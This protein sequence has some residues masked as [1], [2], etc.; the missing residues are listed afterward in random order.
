MKNIK[1]GEKNIKKPP[2]FILFLMIFIILVLYLIYSIGLNFKPFAI[3]E[4]EGYAVS[5]KELVE[6]LLKSDLNAKQYIDAVKIEEDSTIYKK[7]ASYFVGENKK[8]KINLDYPIYINKNIALLN[9]SDEGTLITTDLETVDAYKNS[10]LTN[11][12][13]YNVDSFERADY[14]DY[15]FLKN[16]DNVFINS[17]EMTIKTNTNTYVIP[18]NSMLSF[19]EEYIAY[20]HLE[21]GMFKYKSIIDIDSSSKV[22]INGIEYVRTNNEMVSNSTTKEYT[23][24]QFLTNLKLVREPVIKRTEEPKEE[25]NTPIEDNNDN[26][27]EEPSQEPQEP[28]KPEEIKWTKPQVTATDFIA[29]V[30]TADTNLSIYDPSGVIKTA[31]TFEIYKNGKIYMRNQAVSS[32]TIKIGVLEPDTEYEIRGIYRYSDK[33]DKTIENE[34]IKQKIKTKDISGLSPI[35]LSFENGK[36]YYNKIEIKNIKVASDMKENLE[37]L[38]GIKRAEITINGKTETI[39]SNGLR[40][41]VNGQAITFESKEGLKSNTEVNYEIAFYDISNNKVKLENNIGKTNTCM[42]KPDVRIE[43][44]DSN[45]GIDVTLRT[46]VNNKDNV[47]I[48]NLHYIVYSASNTIVDQGI[49]NSNIITPKGL[50]LSKYYIVKVFGTYD[51]N[52]DNGIIENDNLGE[53]SFTTAKL[54]SFGD[55]YVDLGIKTDKIKNDSVTLDLLINTTTNKTNVELLKM[56]KQVSIVLS[57]RNEM[58]REETL[59]S[60]KLASLLSLEEINIPINRLNSNTNYSIEVRAILGIGNS[61]KEVT[62]IINGPKSF[63][64]LRNDAKLSIRNLFILKDMIDFDINIYDKDQAVKNGSVLLEILNTRDEVVLR[65]EIITTDKSY[66]ST[67]IQVTDLNES[68]RYYI[69]LTT[70]KYSVRQEESTFKSMSFEFN[71]DEKRISNA[72]RNNQNVGVIWT[73]NV[74]GKISLNSIKKVAKLDNVNLIDVSSNVNWYS[75]CFNTSNGY[76]KEYSEGDKILKLGLGNSTSQLYIYD[77]KS[78]LQEYNKEKI[79]ISFK[80]RLSKSS[81]KMYL[82]NGK[83]ISS[84]R[85]IEITPEN[86]TQLSDDWYEFNSEDIIPDLSTEQYIGISLQGEANSYVDIMELQARINNSILQNVE[87][88]EYKYDFISNFNLD[89][90]LYDETL[91]TMDYNPNVTNGVYYLKINNITDNKTEYK[92]YSDYAQ[93][94]SND[95]GENKNAIENLIVE[96]NLSR[97]KQYNIS[98][99]VRNPNVKERE[100]TLSSIYFNTYSQEIKNISSISDYLEIQPNGAYIFS[101]DINLDSGD[102]KFG[103]ENLYFNGEIDFNGKTIKRKIELKEDENYKYY[104]FYGLTENATFKNLYF[105]FSINL[106]NAEGKTNVAISEHN[107]GLVYEN[108]GNI[109]NVI[110]NLSSSTASPNHN[111]AIIGYT[112]TGTLENFVIYLNSNFYLNGTGALGFVNNVGGTIKNGYL[113]PYPNT[114]YSIKPAECGESSIKIG[115]LVANATDNGNISNVYSLVNIHNKDEETEQT[116]VTFTSGNVIGSLTNSTVSNIYSVGLGNVNKI[117]SRNGKA[118][119]TIGQLYNIDDNNSVI[120]SYFFVD[121]LVDN[122]EYNVK[123]NIAALSNREFQDNLLNI[124]GNGQFIVDNTIKDYFPQVRLSEVM[125]RQ[126]KIPMKKTIETD[127][128]ILMTKILEDGDTEKIIEFT[129][130]N[131]MEAK[132]DKLE[133]E[134]LELDEYRIHSNEYCGSG[135]LF[136]KC[137][138]QDD[139]GYCLD[140][141]GNR[142]KVEEDGYTQEYLSGQTTKLIAKIRIPL[143]KTIDLKGFDSRKYASKYYLKSIKALGYGEKQYIDENGYILIKNEMNLTYY[144]H[145]QN[146]DDWKRINEYPTENYRIISD[147]DF[148]NYSYTDYCIKSSFTGIID[149]KNLQGKVARLSNLGK[150]ENEIKTQL[151]YKLSDATISN[152]MIDGFYQIID[153]KNVN[154]N[155]FL[156]GLIGV[157][158]QGTIIENVHLSNVKLMT[159]TTKNNIDDFYIGG[160]IANAELTTIKNCSISY[161]DSTPAVPN[162]SDLDGNKLSTA[163]IGGLVGLSRETKIYN[164]F[165]TNIYINANLKTSDGI[166][167]LVGRYTGEIINCYTTGQIK[168]NAQEIGGIFGRTL[169]EGGTTKDSN[170]CNN[171]YSVV[172]IKT[173]SSGLGGI[174]GFVDTTII[175]QLE[176]NI[177]IGNLYTSMAGTNTNSNRIYGNIS[178]TSTVNYAYKEQLING[179]KIS[180]QDKNY[181]RGAKYVVDRENLLLNF[182]GMF[183]NSVYNIIDLKNAYL[184]R[185]KYQ[186]SQDLLPNQTLNKVPENPT[187]E[188]VSATAE[189]DK[190]KIVIKDENIKPVSTSYINVEIVDFEDLQVEKRE[191]NESTRMHTLYLTGKPIY[192]LD[193]YEI[194]KLM[195]RANN[196]EDYEAEI[197]VKIDFLN[198]KKISSTEEWAK[199]FCPEYSGYNYHKVDGDGK[200]EFITGQNYKIT[201]DIDLTELQTLNGETLTTPTKLEIGRLVGEDNSKE[202]KCPIISNF[203]LSTRGTYSAIF[204]SITKELKNIYFKDID[205]DNAYGDYTGIV[206]KCTAQTIENLKFTN[207]KLKSTSSFTAVISYSTCTNIKNIKLENIE[208]TGRAYVAGFMGY[209]YPGTINNIEANNITIDAKKNY[210]GG[211]F[212]YIPNYVSSYGNNITNLKITNSS[213]KSKE[214]SIGGVAGYAT[215]KSNITAEN[216]AIEGG[217]RYIGGIAGYVYSGNGNTINAK[218]V[219]IKAT[220]YSSSYV[221]G[222]YGYNGSGIRNSSVYGI[223]II[224]SGSTEYVGGIMG[225]GSG[226]YDTFIEGHTDGGTQYNII[227]APYSAKVGG[228]AGYTWGSSVENTATQGLEITGRTMVGG[229]MGWS[230]LSP[231]NRCYVQNCYVKGNSSVGGILGKADVNNYNYRYGTRITN[232]YTDA[233]VSA[234]NDSG[235]GLIGLFDTSRMNNQLYTSLIYNN[236]VAASTVTAPANAG[237]L[238]G[239]ITTS[240]YYL[241]DNTK[242]FYGNLIISNIDTKHPIGNIDNIQETYTEIDETTGEENT[243]TRDVPPEETMKR[244]FNSIFYQYSIENGKKVIDPLELNNLKQ[245]ETYSKKLLFKYN[246]YDFSS[247][248]IETKFPILLAIKDRTVVYTD[249]TSKVFSQNGILLPEASTISRNDS[250]TNNSTTPIKLYSNSLPKYNV[251]VTGVNEINVEFSNIIPNVYFKYEY[252]GKVSNAITLEKRVYTFEYDFKQ[253]FKLIIGNESGEVQ[254]EINPSDIAKRVSVINDDY[255][256]LTYNTLRKSNNIISGEYLNIFGN[257]AL[258]AEG[259]IY[260]INTNSIG[261]TVTNGIKLLDKTNKIAEYTYSGNIIETYYEFSKTISEKDE[262]IVPYRTFIKNGKLFVLDGNLDI[263]GDSIIIDAY[264]NKE[265][266]TVLGTDGILYDLKEKIN[267]PSNFKNEEILQMTN[268]INTNKNE[269]LIMYKDGRVYAFNYVTGAVLYDSNNESNSGIMSN[270]KKFFKSLFKRNISLYEPEQKDYSEA[271]ELQEKLTATPIETAKIKLSERNVDVNSDANINGNNDSNNTQNTNGNSS[272]TNNSTSS[273]ENSNSGSNSSYVTVYDSTTNKYLVYK[274]SDIINNESTTAENEKII[275]ETEKINLTPALKEFYQTA[276]GNKSMNQNSGIYL[277]ILSVTI[278][279]VI[280]VVMYKKKNY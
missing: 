195:Y 254:Q 172:N 197:A 5:G 47:Q 194:C 86:S 107:S 224:V 105:D 145:I 278:V 122:N 14:N 276:Q 241:N 273:S 136:E 267:Y 20:Y 242:Y 44:V 85:L 101:N 186:D 137:V 42:R 154:Q 30:Y 272:T 151:F 188:L 244:L 232:C 174:G 163:R 269:V 57:N 209:S 165:V 126:L 148:S 49:L 45:D 218:N 25:N 280:L 29:N 260:N 171:C 199:E 129:I 69:K 48:S 106:R 220:N 178:S 180:A 32:G 200:P 229:I 134:G 162:I 219:S 40:R 237:G 193:S 182:N 109:N 18:T 222:I 266:Q 11:G 61:R 36:K 108:N 37:T 55:I 140:K 192:Y 72:K 204:S 234:N 66:D 8:T 131:P 263:Y 167:G 190:I 246:T 113:T 201:G 170:I 35:T 157:T 114:S 226:V 99:V 160:L 93:K 90:N 264:N 67:R 21:D 59:N 92:T 120:D 187:L 240:L 111:F 39:S 33:D 23:Y 279:C 51:L 91:K 233:T 50:E 65:Q 9:M 52:D 202:D 56:I 24:K 256:Y 177:S 179:F 34:F 169:R 84:D 132:I 251:Y 214:G 173:E 119:P 10:T 128:D 112:N 82:Q 138:G 158:K 26:K 198:Y 277:I 13:L 15:L 73:N 225:Y 203:S 221:G 53:I 210:I 249:S 71:G 265:Y 147:L 141:D 116:N 79:V 217:Y 98:V 135:D 103:N 88:S 155:A 159:K 83:D 60:E 208:C 117:N 94:A 63:T 74:G 255:Y 80:Y 81:L 87:Y 19:A 3:I 17:K 4:Y 22:I 139:E 247:D 78:S 196:A 258:T 31:I 243:I 231:I 100:Y 213:I 28:T 212:G 275:S 41:L 270:A 153:S 96:L 142:I 64:T 215:L 206:G 205:I 16:S 216:I 124:N 168:T 110:V 166:G 149:G 238:F 38:I 257:N 130:F 259:K 274:T 183:N 175:K 207:I 127:A 1:K 261:S 54:D 58:I 211:I 184:P 97:N 46:R 77:L 185:L 102:Y 115:G 43:R 27:T 189:N 235:G 223:N 95:N 2:I 236:Y 121:E 144:Y 68:E 271:M 146:I 176:N 228:V 161:K 133:I 143:L 152:L 181:N 104:L 12:I 227:N 75:E 118:G 156:V 262:N 252:D 6:N 164:C 250:T 89:L 230:Y 62:A 239:K 150:E 268:N 125:P 76:L 123:V 70:D 248:I 7:I 245:E 191:Y 253:P